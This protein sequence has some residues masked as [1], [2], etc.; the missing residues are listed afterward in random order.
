MKNDKK[1]LV[2]GLIVI[3]VGILLIVFSPST[4]PVNIIA[5]VIGALLIAYGVL[6]LQKIF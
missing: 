4:I 3:I 1:K 6:N 2:L 5:Y